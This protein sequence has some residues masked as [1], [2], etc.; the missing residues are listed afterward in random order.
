M[1]TLC[2]K[3]ASLVLDSERS[4]NPS[5][6]F[7]E[8]SSRLRADLGTASLTQRV[9]VRP[10]LYPVHYSDHGQTLCAEVLSLGNCRWLYVTSSL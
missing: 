3:D 5:R 7:S 2:T 6:P 1:A 10:D 4:P 9:K 8:V